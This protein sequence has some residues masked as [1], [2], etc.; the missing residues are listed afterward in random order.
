MHILKRY[1]SSRRVGG[2]MFF[3]KLL[4]EIISI[5][6]LATMVLGIIIKVIDKD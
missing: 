5:S 6:I 1:L 4:I 3:T 2:N